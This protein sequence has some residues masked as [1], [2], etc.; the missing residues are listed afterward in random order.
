MEAWDGR[1][2][3]EAALNERRRRAVKLYFGG[4]TIA[5]TAELC[6]LGKRTVWSAIKADPGHYPRV[7]C[8][9]LPYYNYTRA[10]LPRLPWAFA[11]NSKHR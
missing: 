6:E 3:S 5:K 8:F 11:V 10:S 7:P 1:K 9:A 4:A 2:L